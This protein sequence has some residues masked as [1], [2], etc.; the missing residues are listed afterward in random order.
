[1]LNL[2]ILMLERGGLIIILAYLLMNIS[3]FREQ[4]KQRQR[5]QTQVMLMI[6]F[7]IFAVI[8]NYRG[9]EIM[10]NVPVFSNPSLTLS[11]KSALANTRVLTI[12]IAGLVGGPIVSMVVAIIAAI[13]RYFQGGNQAFIYVLSSLLI[14]A[15]AGWFGK[16][17]LKENE[18]PKVTYA[19][20]VGMLMECVQMACILTFSRPFEH[21]LDLVKFISIPMILVNTVGTGIFLS[22][23]RSSL[24]LEEHAKAVQTSDV[25]GLANA[26]LPYF[27]SG[28]NRDSCESVAKVFIEKMDVAGVQLDNGECVL[29]FEGNEHILARYAESSKDYTRIVG[30]AWQAEEA[31]LQVVLKSEEQSIGH[32]TLFFEQ[33]SDIT[34]ADKRLIEGLGTIFSTQITLGQLEA[35][36]KLLQDAEIKSLQAQVNPHFFFNALNTVSALIRVDSEEARRLLLELS[37][38]FR[39]NLQGTRDVLIPLKQELRQVQAY[40]NLE[41]ARFPNRYVVDFQVEDGLTETLL[42]PFVI[43]ILVENAFKHAF[44]TRKENN[45]IEVSLSHDTQHLLLSVSDNGLG[46][47]DSRLKTLGRQPVSSDLGTGSALENLNRRLV[48]LFGEVAQLKFETSSLGTTVSCRIPI[49]KGDM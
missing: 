29:A 22:I 30:D 27:R 15:S 6:V 26:T 35:Q 20:L 12:S 47:E 40:I 11:S 14:G 16:P 9:I 23:I 19:M 1:M 33:A 24:Q 45:R 42:P 10:N 2:A 38:F 8:S 41:Q 21:G 18:F 37:H 4:M 25:L 44:G 48:G 13:V 5:W 17:S 28:F 36:H 31:L 43:Q 7:S 39:S 32:L 3:Y 49:Q 34:S 46:I